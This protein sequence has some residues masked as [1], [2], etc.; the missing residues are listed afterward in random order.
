MYSIYPSPPQKIMK[1]ID[2]L[3][4]LGQVFRTTLRKKLIASPGTL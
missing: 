3:K 4:S 1:K 2:Y